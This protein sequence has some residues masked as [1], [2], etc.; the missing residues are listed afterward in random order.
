M[1]L[2]SH[3]AQYLTLTHSSSLQCNIAMWGDGGRV[4]GRLRT[5][6]RVNISIAKD[7]W[8]HSA[9][10]EKQ[11]EQTV[12]GNLTQGIVTR[13]FY[14]CFSVSSSIP[15][16]QAGW[17]GQRQRHQHACLCPLTTAAVNKS[18]TGGHT[19]N[20]SHWHCISDVVSLLWKLYCKIT[21]RV[22]LLNT[23][24]PSVLWTKSSFFSCFIGC[25]KV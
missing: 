3:E 15:A 14:L 19:L 23:R 13:L 25:I 4:S 10:R 2:F 5:D 8:D 12:F 18:A 11:T 22:T 1:K 16:C 17:C 20:I 21:H 7:T 24:E 6:V 9:E